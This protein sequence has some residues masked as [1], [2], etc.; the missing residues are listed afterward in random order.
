MR[1]WPPDA[2]TSPEWRWVLLR[3]FA[4]GSVRGTPLSKA[5]D[6]VAAARRLGQFSRILARTAQEELK[7]DLGEHYANATAQHRIALA[8]ALALERTIAAVDAAAV[9]LKAP[10]VLIKGAA[11]AQSRITPFTHREAGDVD[12]LIEPN[13]AAEFQQALVVRGFREKGALRP[14][15]HLPVLVDDSG[16]VIEVHTGISNLGRRFELHMSD[17]VAKGM[18][19][20]AKGLSAYAHVPFREFLLA[21]SISHGIA[22]HGFL[23]LTY[24][25]VKMLADVIDI[26]VEKLGSS[27]GT[28][29]EWLKPVVSDGELDAVRTVAVHL[30]D[31]TFEAIWNGQAPASRL[32]RHCVLGSL[33]ERYARGLWLHHVAYT[34]SYQLRALGPQQFVQQVWSRLSRFTFTRIRLGE[35]EYRKQYG[36]EARG[37]D[38]AAFRWSSLPATLEVLQRTVLGHRSK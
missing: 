23:P 14:M 28:I 21:H 17:L 2:P 7:R 15:Y 38:L 20:T 36:I 24:P 3:A 31:G 13:R 26:G 12:V 33:D 10:Y 37:H 1:F 34:R 8:R 27:S 30:T 29:A 18:L 9:A 6:A 35:R 11:L 5:S 4:D 25:L 22:H 19:E 16:G 32:L